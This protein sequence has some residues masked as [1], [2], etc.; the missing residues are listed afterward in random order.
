MARILYVGTAGSDDPTR[1]GF[2]FTFALGAV[3][4][5]HQPEVF[6]AG[7]A[8]YLMKEDVAAAVLPV[9]MAPLRE[10]F[11]KVVE[12]RVPVYV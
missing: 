7:E 11:E 8:A 1:A 2:P 4:A 5:G 10:M 3:E 9:G 6:L 12:H